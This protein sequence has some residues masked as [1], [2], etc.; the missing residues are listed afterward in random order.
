MVN[1][2]LRA[3]AEQ[4]RSTSIVDPVFPEEYLA[5]G[6]R[7]TVERILI[8]TSEGEVPVFIHRANDRPSPC[9]LF[10]NIHGGGFVRPLIDTNIHFCSKAAVSI[11][12][13][14]VDIDYSLAPE[15]PYPVAFHQCY[16][17]VKWVFA[18]GEELGSRTDLI[19]L[20]GH[21]AGAN[22]TAAI[23]LKAAQTKEFAPRVQIHD[24]G[25]YDMATDPADK[26][27]IQENL[28]PLDRCRAFNEMYTW[29]DPQCVKDP[30]VSPLL[31][32]DEWLKEQPDALVITGGRDTFRFEGEQ[33][34]LR[35]AAN[36]TKVTVKRFADSPHGFTVNCV[37]KWQEAQQLIID[38][39]LRITP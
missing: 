20:G 18:H 35:L 26:P 8:Q 4:V 37:G 30:Y 19:A 36:G 31:A 7:E 14:V 23:M 11:Q 24:F 28:V 32:P 5:Y 3:M 1:E 29:A 13:V 2:R 17:V 25:A 16:D 38:T 27:G 15:Y 21:S 34:A 6:G 12:G 33:Y 9:R 39:L 10:I 22:L